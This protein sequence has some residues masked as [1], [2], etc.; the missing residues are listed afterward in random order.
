[1]ASSHERAEGQLSSF[2]DLRHTTS[3]VVSADIG[4]L[5]DSALSETAAG[6]ANL[7]LALDLKFGHSH[8][9]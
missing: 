5:L 4:G 7:L 3:T 9:D 8:K 6:I 2:Q 1:V